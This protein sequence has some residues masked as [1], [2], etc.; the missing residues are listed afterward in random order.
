MA[1]LRQALEHNLRQIEKLRYLNAFVNEAAEYALILWDDSA[2]RRAEGALMT[3]ESRKLSIKHDE[4]CIACYSQMQSLY[5]AC[6][7]VRAACVH[8]CVV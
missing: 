3:N 2:Q 1:K 7:C 6:V 8:V 4:S 5:I